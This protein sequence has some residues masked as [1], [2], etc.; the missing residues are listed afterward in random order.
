MNTRYADS[1]SNTTNT[2]IKS[3]IGEYAYKGYWKLSLENY[4]PITIT[5]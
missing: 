2:H 4:E 1:V 5:L 3:F